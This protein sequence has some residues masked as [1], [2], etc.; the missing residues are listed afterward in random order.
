MSVLYSQRGAM[1][2]VTR[3][4]RAYF[5]PV[6][7]ATTTPSIFDAA[8]SGNFELDN[9]PQP[10]IDSGWITNF[11]RTAGTA[12]EA[13]RSGARGTAQQQFRAK[14]QASVGFDFR[15]WGKLQMAI[16]SGSQHIN[17]LA[18]QS[19]ASP[20]ASGGAAILAIAVLAGST[21]SELSIGLGAVNGFNVGDLVAVD[22]D[23]AQETG[24]IGE[25]IPGAFVKNAADVLFDPNYA[26]RVTFNIGRVAAKTQS[27]LQLA[28]PLL[29]GVPASNASVQK[30]I[31]FVDREGGS[32]FQEWSGLFVADS[33]TGAR[34]YYY[35][36]RLRPASAAQEKGADIAGAFD[37][38]S[39][40]TKLIALPT[41]DA[42][43]NEQVLCYRSY[44]PAQTAAVY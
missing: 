6:N 23:Y 44:V 17:L 32:F 2:P 27:T 20:T 42:I 43:D 21:A 12:I 39:L 16:S 18:E 29:A 14:A 26:R 24:Y 11:E 8:Q 36:P 19:N 25:G 15:E 28:Q 7:R 37:G 35:Y 9:P 41:K 1:H 22:M 33:E 38:W 5:A 3:R 10:W 4:M 13:V 34:V 30:V 40:R 31:G